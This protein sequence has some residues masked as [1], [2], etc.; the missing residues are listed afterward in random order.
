MASHPA[1]NLSSYISPSQPGD[2]FLLS[3]YTQ[4]RLSEDSSHCFIYC[5]PLYLAIS[6][7]FSL[8]SL[9]CLAVLSRL[10]AFFSTHYAFDIL[11]T[12]S[13]DID[14]NG[15]PRDCC[16]FTLSYF[17]YTCGMTNRDSKYWFAQTG[18]LSIACAPCLHRPKWQLELSGTRFA[19]PNTKTWPQSRHRG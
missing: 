7:F 5:T 17:D 8:H 6:P 9:T 10:I 18:K 4:L 12:F 3:S 2:Y 11:C 19:L 16:R 15:P 1:A 14:H 13:A